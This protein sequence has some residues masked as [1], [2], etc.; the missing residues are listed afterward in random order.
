M[1]NLTSENQAPFIPLSW[2]A[3]VHADEFILCPV[4]NTQL[5][6]DFNLTSGIYLL[7][8]HK[9]LR[10][11]STLV[12]C[13]ALC[14]L[15]TFEFQDGTENTLKEGETEVASHFKN[16]NVPQRHL[17]C[18]TLSWWCSWETVGCQGS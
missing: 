15:L 5:L 14:V 13:I 2:E 11:P 3:V 7:A 10:M 16:W 1:Y 9:N 6:E 12:P 4:G 17:W 18:L 8:F